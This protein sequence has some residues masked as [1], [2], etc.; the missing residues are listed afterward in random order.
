MQLLEGAH[1]IDRYKII[2]Y[3]TNSI[4]IYLL[5]QVFAIYK[6]ILLKLP[7]ESVIFSANILVDSINSRII[8]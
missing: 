7:K 3:L 5:S 2:I 8:Q 6:T 1:T 4:S